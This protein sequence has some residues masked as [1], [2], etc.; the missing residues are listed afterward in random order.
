MLWLAATVIFGMLAL[1]F[2]VSSLR[3]LLIEEMV[4]AGILILATYYSA[5]QAGIIQ[6]V[7]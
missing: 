5:V 3:Y 6:P 7:V 2:T 1:G 4:A